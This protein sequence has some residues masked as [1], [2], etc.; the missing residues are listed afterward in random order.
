LTHIQITPISLHHHVDKVSNYI[1]Q[2]YHFFPRV[3]ELLPLLI[4]ICCILPAEF[5]WRDA[6]NLESQL[7]ED[8]IIVR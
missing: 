5:N 3:Y 4:V 1:F 7:S 8:E 2:S 6:L